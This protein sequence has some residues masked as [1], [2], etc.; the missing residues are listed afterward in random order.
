MYRFSAV[1][2]HEL[3]LRT[4]A[5]YLVEMQLDYMEELAFEKRLTNREYEWLGIAEDLEQQNCSYTVSSDAFP[6]GE[7]IW[8]TRAG[9]KW[10]FRGQ[11]REILLERDLHY[12]GRE[13]SP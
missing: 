4:T 7:G 6:K 1:Q 12:E 11:S 2:R 9:V 5:V 8:G 10:N 13:V 3:A